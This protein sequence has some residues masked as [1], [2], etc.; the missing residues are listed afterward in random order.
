MARV[1]SRSMSVHRLVPQMQLTGG[2]ADATDAVGLIC[3]LPEALT[4]EVDFYGLTFCGDHHVICS[5][6]RQCSC[7]W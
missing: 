2:K 6:A 5:F 4:N 1:M 3:S 7:T